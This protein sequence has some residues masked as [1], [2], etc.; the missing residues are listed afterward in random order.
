MTDTSATIYRTRI[1]CSPARVWDELTATGIPRHWMRGSVLN[2]SLAEGSTYVMNHDGEALFSGTVLTAEPPVR[3]ALTFNP[4][5]NE[6]VAAEAPGVLEYTLEQAG[7]G[8]E[9]T[10][11][12]T[13]LYGASAVS[14]DHDTPGIYAG[15]KAMLESFPVA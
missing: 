5:W 1:A 4:Q 15:L 3:L 7:A 14:V 13:G 2:G 9:L 6:R 8:C 11:R 12:I 10:V